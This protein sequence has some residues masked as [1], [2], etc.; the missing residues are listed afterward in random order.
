MNNQPVLWHRQY[1]S[2]MGVARNMLRKQYRIEP[3]SGLGDVELG[4]WV[5]EMG[6]TVRW[7]PSG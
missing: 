4:Y 7:R 3:L 2:V 6:E 5:H 1:S